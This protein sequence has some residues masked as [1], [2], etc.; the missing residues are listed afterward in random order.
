MSGNR[1]ALLGAMQLLRRLRKTA[2]CTHLSEANRRDRQQF[3]RQSIRD[4]THAFRLDKLLP[5]VLLLVPLL[6]LLLL[7]Q[8]RSGSARRPKTLNGKIY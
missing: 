3:K 5:V 7:A 8:G 6:L 1:L 4:N 2:V